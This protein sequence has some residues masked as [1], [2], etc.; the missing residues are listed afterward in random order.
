MNRSSGPVLIAYDGSDDARAAVAAAGGLLRAQPAVV[1]CVWTPIATSASA[2]TLGAP[3]AVAF[4]GADRL[5]AA[6]RDTAQALA[7]EGAALAREAGLEAE[8]R[9]VEGAGAPWHAI[10]RCADELDAGV[11]VSGTRGRSTFAAAV[12]GSTAQG[13]LH[14]ANRP[15]L[16][17]AHER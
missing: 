6:A 4:A 2:A 9:A 8:P 17:V 3:A 1:A 14:H 16:V 10:V 5:D 13:L 15:V 11:I 7:G 12:L